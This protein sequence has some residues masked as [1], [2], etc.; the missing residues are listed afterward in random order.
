MSLAGKTAFVTGGGSGVGAVIALA[1]AE[2]GAEVVICGRRMEPLETVAARHPGIRA[3]LCDITDETAISA[4]IAEAAPDI[5]IANAGA[6]ESAPFTRTELAAFERMV[7]VNL[8]GTFLT[9][10]E[11]A[12]AMKDK[13]WGRLIAIASTAGLKGYPYVAPYAAA[14]HGVIGL[15]K[16]VALEL[17]RKGITA[18]ALCPGFLDTEM[19]ERSIANIV[20]KTGRSAKEARSSL[21]ATNPMHRLV[22]PEDVARAALWLCG[23]GSEMVTG[24]A[25]SISGGET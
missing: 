23:E 11:G 24:Q 20:E 3:V 17:A 10:R 4:A 9:L 25:I 13:P 6:S 2:A 7:S 8:T 22:P 1:F 18:N 21:E 5:V 12:K 14:K 16:S 15:V 19:T